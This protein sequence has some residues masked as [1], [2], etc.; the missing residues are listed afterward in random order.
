MLPHGETLEK[1]FQEKSWPEIATIAK[2]MQ[3]RL[4]HEDDDAKKL[5]AQLRIMKQS[6][7]EYMEHPSAMDAR[8]SELHES[9]SSMMSSLEE[10]L[11]R[12]DIDRHEFVAFLKVLLSKLKE[13]KIRKAKPR[14]AEFTKHKK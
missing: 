5:E 11:M 9:L 12:Y 4:E 6:L 13:E 7:I 14:R 10:Q 2:A 1:K 3:I 8:T